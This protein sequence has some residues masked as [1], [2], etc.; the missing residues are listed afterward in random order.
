MIVRKTCRV[1]KISLNINNDKGL[2]ILKRPM[3]ET[4]TF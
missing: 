1:I 4:G 3:Y 2:A